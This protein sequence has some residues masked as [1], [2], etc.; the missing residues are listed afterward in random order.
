[1]YVQTNTCISFRSCSHFVCK[2]LIK[3]SR[4]I[5]IK[6]LLIIYSVSE[7]DIYIYIYIY[8][9]VCLFPLMTNNFYELWLCLVFSRLLLYPLDMDGVWR[10]V[11]L[12]VARRQKINNFLFPSTR[13]RKQINYPKCR[14]FVLAWE[15]GQCPNY[16]SKLSVPRLS[17]NIL[18]FSGFLV[19]TE[20]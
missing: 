18:P 2:I 8:I 20:C 19:R 5:F 15:E 11:T 4:L 9:Y 13:R 3:I 16:Q 6:T 17:Y 14:S 7:F 10:T 1:M 12:D